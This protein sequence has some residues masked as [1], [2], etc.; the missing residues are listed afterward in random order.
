MKNIFHVCA[1]CFNVSLDSG[2]GNICTR[3]LWTI[4]LHKSYV[5]REMISSKSSFLFVFSISI[6]NIRSTKTQFSTG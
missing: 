4:V 6:N 5:H 1:Q 2:A 3:S